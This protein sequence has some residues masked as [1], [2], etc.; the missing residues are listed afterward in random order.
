MDAKEARKIAEEKRIE[1]FNNQF[2]D[3]MELIKTAAEK[4]IIKNYLRLPLVAASAG[5]Q[6][7]IKAEIENC[8]SSDNLKLIYN[9][10][11]NYATQIYPL[12]LSR[13]EELD[14][15]IAQIVNIDA[16]IV[17]PKTNENEPSI[18]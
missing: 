14:K 16:I 10:Y 1:S 8:E 5:L 11:P 17:Q 15:A 13:K 3:V 18:K 6:D 12:I 2:N 9:Q 4:G 7:K